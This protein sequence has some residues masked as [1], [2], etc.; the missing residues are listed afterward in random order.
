MSL[1]KVKI[2]D[3]LS[4]TQY[5][6]VISEKK[7][8]NSSVY[9]LENERGLSID[10]SS[11]VIEEGMFSSSTFDKEEKV[12]ATDL[13]YI[14]KN[15]GDTIFTVVY[16]KQL[17]PEDLLDKLKLITDTSKISKSDVKDWINGEERELIGYRISDANFGR[18][19]VIDLTVPL[20]KTK[21]YDNRKRLVDHRSIVSLIIKGTK[22]SLK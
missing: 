8:N 12:N 2:N 17:K 18:S 21:T 22:Y 10:V 1:T 9:T 13:E 4:E 6:K 7:V 16:F 5:Y 11:T 15:V 19:N 14:F 20:D 3:F